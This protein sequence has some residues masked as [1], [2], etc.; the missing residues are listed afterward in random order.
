MSPGGGPAPNAPGGVLSSSA[1]ASF[2]A[3]TTISDPQENRFKKLFP[4]APLD[5]AKPNKS[6][7]P[8]KTKKDKRSLLRRLF[9]IKPPGE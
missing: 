6:L 2:P 8:D 9:D 1:S 4:D 5:D 7:L 3:V